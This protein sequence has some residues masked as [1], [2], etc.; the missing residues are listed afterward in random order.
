MTPPVLLPAAVAVAAV[1][2]GLLL[3]LLPTGRA[4]L[5]GPL[6]SF[7]LAAALT[8]VVTHL[9]PEAFVELGA[10]ALF[11]FAAATALSAWARV[12][13]RLAGGEHSHAGLKAGYLG[14]LG[15]H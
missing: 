1:A 15:H 8:V 9:L 3:G 11:V 7:A 4:R 14:L 13:G 6:R 10:P 2:L 12:V 5:A